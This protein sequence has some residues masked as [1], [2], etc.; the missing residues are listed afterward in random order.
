MAR[1]DIRLLTFNGNGTEDPEQHW[2]LYEFVWMVK[3]GHNVD[4]K[5][6]QMIINLR[7]H[8]LDWFMK[9]C[10][11]LTRT[12]K[13]TLDDIISMMVSKFRKPK[14]ESLCINEIKEIKQALGES[15]WDFD[16][17]FKTLMAKVIFQM[18]DVQHKEWF[19]A[20]LLPHI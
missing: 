20:M 9:L 1:T 19:T 13:N 18:S 14:Y 15:V 3:I 5:K 11:T 16:Q 7:G 8:V 10:V 4:I 6:A 2:F 17:R 12:M